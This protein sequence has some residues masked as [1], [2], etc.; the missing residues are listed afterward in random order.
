MATD[1]RNCRVYPRTCGGTC[2]VRRGVMRVL[3]LSPHLRGNLYA[4]SGVSALLG[5]IP[6]LAGEPGTQHRQTYGAM[7]YPR[8]CGGTCSGT[9]WDEA[10]AGLSPHL[11]GNPALPMR[12]RPTAGS[13]PALAGEPSKDRLSDSQ[14]AVYPR[15]CGGTICASSMLVTPSGLSPHLRGNLIG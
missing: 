9:R 10:E 13:I 5:S 6:A 3:G 8:T 2:F 4:P 14:I 11:R 7:V 12:P 1:R 15:T